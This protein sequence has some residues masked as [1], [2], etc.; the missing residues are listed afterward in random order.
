MPSK[1]KIAVIPSTT[2]PTRF[3]DRPAKWLLDIAATRNDATFEF[4]DLRDYPMP[5]FEDETSPMWAPP[6]DETAV[7]W[8]QKIAEYDGFIFLTAEYNHGIP[9]VLKNALDYAYNEF[10]RKPA[11]FVGYGGVGAA[12]A[13]EQLRLVLAEMQVASLKHTVH[14][15]AGEFIAMLRDGKD[16][17][18]FPYLD[19]T[20]GPM[21]DNLVW[22]ASALKAGRDSRNQE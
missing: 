7:R 14:I 20:V 6:A 12:R 21:L 1:L 16:F 13:V 18:D 9:A 17:A 4:V 22:W 8:G 10:V 3:A 19:D 5:F 15:N 11:T 2:R